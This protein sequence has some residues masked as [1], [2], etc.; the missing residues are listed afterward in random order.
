MTHGC[1]GPARSSGPSRI[2]TDRETEVLEAIAMGLGTAGIARALAISPLTVRTHLK[3]ILRKLDAH[4]KVEAV[5]SAYR[6]GLI[7]PPWAVRN[8]LGSNV[9]LDRPGS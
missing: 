1:Q 7:E 8:D 5:A 4:S 2:L 3:S 9:A 6:L